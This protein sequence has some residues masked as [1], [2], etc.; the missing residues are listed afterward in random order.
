ML[1]NDMLEDTVF[2]TPVHLLAGKEEIQVC[3]IFLLI[4]NLEQF[5]CVFQATFILMGKNSM[6]TSIKSK[7]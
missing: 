4:P 5:I 7:S 6:Q 2:I 3:I 1:L